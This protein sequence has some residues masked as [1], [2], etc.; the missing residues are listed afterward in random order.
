MKKSLRQKIEGLPTCPGVYSFK[1]RR[2]KVIYVGKA[3]SLRSRVRSY[4]RD[5]EPASPRTSVLVR[6]IQDLD[7]IAT[8]SEVEALILECNL[9]KHFKPRY[10][11]N[12]KDDKKYPYIKVTTR[13]PFPSVCPTRNL[14]HDGARYFGPY[15]DAKAMRRTLKL[16]T[17]IFP[18]RTCR[19][20]LPLKN[21]DRGCLNYHIGKCVG[22]CRGDVSARSYRM[23]IDEVCQFLSGRMSDLIRDLT[24]RME[25]DAS[26]LRF[27]SAAR[28]RDMLRALEKVSERQIMITSSARDR[29][30]IAV[31]VA[32]GQ[33]VGFVLKVREGKLVGKEVYR[34]AFEVEPGSQELLN[35]FL[36]QYVAVTTEIPD[37]ILIEEATEGTA[38]IEEWLRQ[39]AGRTI[40][41]QSPKGGKGRDLLRMA[42]ENAQI[43]ITQMVKTER[44]EPKVPKSIEDL[45]RVLRLGE[46][47]LRI[48]AF[49]IS[50]TGGAYPVG[51]RVFYK[52]GRALKGMYRH[53]SI[54]T[55]SGQDDFAMMREVLQRAWSHVADGS[56][57][58]PDLVLID[59]GKGQIT[60]AI[61]GILR[62]GC[63]EEDLPPVIGI[64]K[65][66]D[67]VFVPGR[68]D[69]V[70]IPHES[71]ALRLLQRVR[72]EAHR[73][74]VSYHRRRRDGGSLRSVL[75]DIPGIGPEIRKRLLAEFGSVDRIR[76]M[77]VD[78]LARIRGVSRRRAQ[79]VLDSLGG[80]GS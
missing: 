30:V 22:P 25:K 28:L 34:L 43:L 33:A 73:F 21:P 46:P 18:M 9:I 49:D 52:N 71:P 6:K 67:E 3:K 51:S 79:A 35:S 53:Y 75:E 39:K 10:N 13:E 26:D 37:E 54:K 15:T 70:Q 56:E 47:P 12:L 42:A 17:D 65:R 76:G 50:T 24:A 1:D 44:H 2:G 62:A 31:R 68:S 57:E 29:D 69:P 19:R 58:R 78:D 23:L 4:F 8:R 60:S 16:L 80:E 74:A 72:D 14:K 61:E 48:A 45:A 55:V 32:D 5:S 59:G 66:L 77:E 63:G 27:E 36:E 20:R 64:A 41:V 7:F 40:R 11:V 38:L